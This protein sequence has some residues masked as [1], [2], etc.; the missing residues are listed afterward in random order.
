[1]VS[2]HRQSP[3]IGRADSGIFSYSRGPVKIT[4]KIQREKKWNLSTREESHWPTIG[5][6]ERHNVTG[7]IYHLFN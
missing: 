4:S 2:K 7:V 1:M 3:V 6:G 5:Y